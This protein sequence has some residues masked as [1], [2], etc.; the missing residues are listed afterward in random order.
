MM[1]DANALRRQILNCSKCP[2]IVKTRNKPVPGIGRDKAKIVLI[3]LA[4]G[5]DGADMTGIPFTRDPSGELINELLV[6]IGLSREQDTFITNLVKCNPKDEKGCNR[7]PSKIEI[8][9]CSPFLLEEIELVK[10]RLVVCFGKDAS[11]FLLNQKI[12]KMSQI[13]GQMQSI[14]GRIIV[15]FIHPAFVIRGAYDRKKYVAEFSIVG[16]VFRDLSKQ[17]EE[18]SRLD[19]LLML[20][21]ASKSDGISGN[22]RGKT[23]LQKLLFLVQNELQKQG[24]KARYAFRPYRYGPYSRELY[25]DV[26]W[27]KMKNLLDIQTDFH[28]D[29]GVIAEFTITDTGRERLSLLKDMQIY[30]AIQVAI[31]TVFSIYGEMGVTELVETVHKEFSGYH[32]PPNGKRPTALDKFFH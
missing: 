2:A 7:P 17:E 29:I 20:I 12:V 21:M 16:D 6:S 30:K 18:L 15:P 11:E 5:K 32:K 31:S 19:I 9:N 13:H 8:A 24:Y 28:E 22:I 23:K 4:P 25:T 14:N 1:A 27:L 3:G 26:Q 10:P